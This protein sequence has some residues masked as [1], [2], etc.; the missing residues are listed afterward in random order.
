MGASEGVKS[1]VHRC[2]G[3][4][5]LRVVNIVDDLVEKLV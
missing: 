3:C 2:E 5:V 4:K 1:M